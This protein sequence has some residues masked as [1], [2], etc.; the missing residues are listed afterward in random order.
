MSEY[1]TT[2]EAAALQVPFK[3]KKLRKKKKRRVTAEENS[4]STFYLVPVSA[5]ASTALLQPLAASMTSYATSLPLNSDMETPEARQDHGKRVEESVDTTAS[6]KLALLRQAR[7]RFEVA[8]EKSNR[9]AVAL[10]HTA[11]PS[12]ESA[13]A[14]ASKTMTTTVPSYCHP[15]RS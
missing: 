1:Y 3:S 11:P 4:V 6:T 12:L 15:Q 10:H 2:E 7:R 9:A 13:S 14:S 5:S 8:R